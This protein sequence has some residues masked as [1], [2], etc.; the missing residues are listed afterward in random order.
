MYE[1]LGVMSKVLKL[2]RDRETAEEEQAKRLATK[3]LSEIEYLQEE[4]RV[5]KRPFIVRGQDYQEQLRKHLSPLPSPREA[6][7]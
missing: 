2:M 4:H 7:D 3:I 1:A 6:I 5:F